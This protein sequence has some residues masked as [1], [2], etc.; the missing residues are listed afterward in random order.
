MKRELAYLVLRFGVFD[1]GDFEPTADEVYADSGVE[2]EEGISGEHEALF[3]VRL[4]RKNSGPEV[5]GG[6]T[7]RHDGKG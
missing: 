5:E 3:F 4:E 6:E 2:A 1:K 7:Q